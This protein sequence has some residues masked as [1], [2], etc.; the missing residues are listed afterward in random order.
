MR[1]LHRPQRPG[2]SSLRQTLFVSKISPPI[3]ALWLISLICLVFFL[4]F[5]IRSLLHLPSYDDAGLNALLFSAGLFFVVMTFTGRDVELDLNRSTIRLRIS[6]LYVPI[7]IERHAFGSIYDCWVT[8]QKESLVPFSSNFTAPP[9]KNVDFY[10]LHLFFKFGRAR[11]WRSFVSYKFAYLDPTISLFLNKLV[12]LFP[13]PEVS[14]NIESYT[15]DPFVDNDG[16]RRMDK[17]QMGPPGRNNRLGKQGFVSHEN[18]HITI[19]NA[20]SLSMDYLLAYCPSDSKVTRVTLINCDVGEIKRSDALRDVTELDLS[21]NKIKEIKN[22]EHCPRLRRLSLS[23]NEIARVENLGHLSD[24]EELWL[25]SNNIERIEGLENLSR[26]RRLYL[27]DNRIARIE[28]LGQLKRL[29][30]LCLDRNNITKI[31]N[32]DGLH[33]L[34]ELNLWN[35]EITCRAGLETCPSLKV[36]HL[37]DTRNQ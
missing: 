36:V 23:H 3:A 1:W 31:E 33:E 29:E 12:E 7:W 8:F 20:R 15:R 27:S 14:A 35:N 18:G 16:R 6:F 21:H 10:T 4:V 37:H 9:K 25:C 5:W 22:L 13:N 11:E 19:Y 28:N 2:I 32:L 17:F 34:R 24:L 30:I 26:L